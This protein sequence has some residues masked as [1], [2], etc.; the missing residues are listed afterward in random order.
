M[1]TNVEIPPE[2]VEAGMDAAKA[3][4][5][6]FTTDAALRTVIRAILEAAFHARAVGSMSGEES[7]AATQEHVAPGSPPSLEWRQ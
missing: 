6:I 3:E 1:K 7:L 2:M 4:R 5:W